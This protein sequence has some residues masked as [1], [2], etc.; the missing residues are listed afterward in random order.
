V[1]RLGV[2]NPTSIRR[3]KV[4]ADLDILAT[5]LYVRVDDLLKNTPERAPGP[6]TDRVYPAA[7]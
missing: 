2:A 5:A 1:S 3:L 4:D 7:Q 6:A